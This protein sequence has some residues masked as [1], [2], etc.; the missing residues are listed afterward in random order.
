MLSLE[1]TV[2]SSTTVLKNAHVWEVSSPLPVSYHNRGG[3]YLPAGFAGRRR[4]ISVEVHKVISPFSETHSSSSTSK[5]DAT[6]EICY[7]RILQCRKQLD[8]TV[9]N[10][11]TQNAKRAAKNIE[12]INF[13][14]GS[15]RS[16]DVVETDSGDD[17]TV[18]AGDT[19]RMTLMQ[20]FRDNDTHYNVENRVVEHPFGTDWRAKYKIQLRNFH[21]VET[22]KNTVS[23]QFEEKGKSTQREFI[24]DT[25]TAAN[26]FCEII[27]KNKDLLDSRAEQRLR[28]SLDGIEL[29]Q[30][31]QL[32]LLFDICSGSDIPRS[33]KMNLSDPYVTVRFNGKKIHRTAYISRTEDPIWTLR[34]GSLF[35]WTVDSLDLF[36][37]HDGLIFE[38]KDFD[39]IGGNDSL[40][41]FSISARTLYRW[42]G[43]RRE[44]SLR[45][46]IGQPDYKR[47]SKIA[48]RVRRA[49]DHDLKF[50]NEYKSVEKKAISLPSI[51]AGTG[52]ALKMY[53]VRPCPDPKRM[54]DTA[55]LTSHQI[56]E[57]SLKPSKEWVDIGS[58]RLGKIFVEIIKCDDL[59]NLDTGGS[60][61]NKTDAFVSMVY[62]DCVAKSETIKDCLHPRWMPWSKRAFIFNM[63]HTSSQL[64]LGVFDADGPS[65]SSHDLVGRVSVELSNAVPDTEYFLTYNLYPTAKCPPRDTNRGTV[66]IRLRLEIESERAL[67]TSN[68]SIPD[69]VYVNVESKK[70]FEVVQKTINGSVDM[71]RFGLNSGRRLR[72]EANENCDLI[73]AELNFWDERVKL[74][75]ER[76]RIRAEEYARQQ[77]EYLRE[78]EEIGDVQ[79]DLSAQTVGGFALDPTRAYLYPIQQYLGVACEALRILK[80]ILLWEECYLS[81]W[82]VVGSFSLAAITFFVPWRFIIG[83]T[84]RIVIWLVFGPWM[85]AAD[86]L[87]FSRYSDESQD[88]KKRRL[89]EL[90][91]KRRERHDKLVL[92]AQVAREKAA[93]LRDFKCYLFG[94]HISHVNV[95]KKDRYYDLPLSASSATPYN[96][97][98]K[99]LG[100]QAMDEAGYGKTRIEGQQLVGEMI[101]TIQETPSIHVPKG[102][103]TKE[104]KLLKTQDY[105]SNDSYIDALL[106]VA[107]IVVGAS[108]ITWCGGEPF[109][110]NA[111]DLAEAAVEG[112]PRGA[113]GKG[114]ESVNRGGVG[115]GTD[116][117]N[118]PGKAQVHP[119]QCRTRGRSYAHPWRKKGGPLNG[120]VAG[121][122]YP[123][124]SDS[125]L[126]HALSPCI[127][128]T[129]ISAEYARRTENQNSIVGIPQH[130]TSPLLDTEVPRPMRK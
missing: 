80:N 6:F 50:I 33:D 56:D 98:A 26:D 124:S 69:S 116:S 64:F 111:H 66:T 102:K 113:V 19:D 126:L 8:Q 82:I 118:R 31:E 53:R 47:S 72:I 22:K 29:E 123:G 1:R 43:E 105:D 71:N 88:E 70:D 24:F 120:L 38:V 119:G 106:K 114:A 18:E 49:T 36:R 121:W 67:F 20:S 62:E 109:T 61:G 86:R 103:P 44:F 87:Y 91:L 25:A 74:A 3:H 7:V 28:V 5:E 59:P 68:L 125:S 46:L 48:L 12:K 17:T 78:L 96:P 107:A 27:Q 13:I 76:A 128:A 101:P 45:P 65:L 23:I 73:S 15:R 90:K 4:R 41:A 32:T 21:I 51:G 84:S 57:E 117:V 79:Y 94:N 60:L 55:W 58:G 40:G 2:G 30:G 42:N 100:E 129:V 110:T 108:A 104:T 83:W 9:I 93:K 115:A 89:D 37:S 112:P 52:S 63:S 34:K 127:S 99:S 95:L 77:E 10:P 81:F 16:K 39:T 130:Q 35:I 54:E 85:M 92:E 75:E 97:E 14:T 122:M 11:F